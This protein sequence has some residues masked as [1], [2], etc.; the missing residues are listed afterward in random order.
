M[1]YDLLIQ[2]NLPLFVED[3]SAM[4]G[5][6]RQILTVAEHLAN[7]GVNVG[8]LHSVSQANDKI[9]NNVKHLNAFR[10]HYAKS[11]VRVFCNHFLYFGNTHGNYGMFNPHVKALSPIEINSAEKCFNWTHNW[12]T[13][14]EQ[15]PRI[16]NSNAIKKYVHDKG[17]KVHGDQVI[18]YMIPK[19]I[20]E[21]VKNERKN[22]L[23]WMSAFGKGLKEAIMLYMGLYEKGMT[24][25]FYISIPP[26]RQRKDVQIVHDFLRDSNKFNY[27][28][29]FLGELDYQTTMKNLSN[30]ACL[31]RPGLP[32]ETFGL[33]YLEANK[34]GV[35]VLTHKGDAGEEILTDNNNMFI[36]DTHTA[37]DI[38]DWLKDV[39]T[40]KT[41]IDMKKFNPEVISKKWMKLIEE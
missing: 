37:E 9:I 1:G 2:A 8:I 34:L 16:F 6:E 40:K 31:F 28:I 24:R 21:P 29:T 32:Q 30:S 15:I 20:D 36:D 22:H 13:C 39:E 12:S 5:T 19:G 26:Q 27:P 7:K 25:E 33:V 18:H 41:S 4:G 35:P 38:M 3:G 14:H 17:K 10:H 23:Y 11:K